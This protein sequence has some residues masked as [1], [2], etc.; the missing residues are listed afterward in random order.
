MNS[1]VSMVME[2]DDHACV[3]VKHNNPCGVALGRSALE[4]F[5][6]AYECDT[7]SIF[8]GVVAFNCQVDEDCAR[9]LK[10]L[11]LEVVVAPSF[12]E[13]AVD[14]LSAKKN[15]R[16][17]E[18]ADMKEG[19]SS[20]VEVKSILGGYLLQTVDCSRENAGDLKLVTSR[21]PSDREIDD[22]LS[23]LRIVKH[24]KSNGIVLFKDGQMT[25]VG[26]GQ[27]SRIWALQNAVERSSLELEGSVMASDGFF[28]F[29]DCIELAAKHGI[30]TVI[31][32]GGSM[33]DEEIRLRAEEIGISLIVTGMRHFKH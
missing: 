1:A 10:E 5:S 11:F 27:T 3:A 26:S 28:P 12:T 31:H 2:L 33:K 22:A 4:A 7:V 23:A 13:G 14:V 17:M 32:P 20:K 18:M 16:I 25:G 9:A 24:V 29:A 6:R 19:S 21:K 30:R 8:G 15:L